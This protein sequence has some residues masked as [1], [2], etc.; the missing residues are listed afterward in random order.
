MSGFLVE[1]NTRPQSLFNEKDSSTTRMVMQSNGQTQAN[2]YAQGKVQS[3][4][5]GKG[6]TQCSDGRRYK[7]RIQRVVKGAG[8]GQVIQTAARETLRER[9]TGRQTNREIT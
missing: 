5:T 2:R 3:L 7:G 8:D 6:H 4:E 1:P 9:R